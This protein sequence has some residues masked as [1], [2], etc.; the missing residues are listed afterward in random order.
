M[1]SFHKAIMYNNIPGTLESEHSYRKGLPE[2]T[3]CLLLRDTKSFL[4]FTVP[5]KTTHD[6]FTL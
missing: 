4:D 2:A 1:K 5:Q 3:Q 6:S